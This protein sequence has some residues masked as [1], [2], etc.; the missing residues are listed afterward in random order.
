MA[1]KL[2]ATS[3]IS[4]SSIEKICVKDKT[5]KRKIDANYFTYDKEEIFEPSVNKRG[6][7]QFILSCFKFS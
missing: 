4:S 5:K 2:S 7:I 6:D 1:P 3:A